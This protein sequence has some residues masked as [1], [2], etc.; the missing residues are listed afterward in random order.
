MKRI[1]APAAIFSS[2]QTLIIPLKEMSIVN[3]YLVGMNLGKDTTSEAVFEE[4]NHPMS[5]KVGTLDEARVGA[6]AGQTPVMQRA[7]GSIPA[8][9]N[10]L[11]DS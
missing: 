6:V 10:F 1:G 11:C 7:A 9:N 5:S 2:T 8:R 3:R 4:G